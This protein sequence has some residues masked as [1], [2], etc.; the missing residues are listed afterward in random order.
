MIREISV[1]LVEYLGGEAACANW[2]VKWECISAW[3]QA[4][5][6]FQREQEEEEEAR[7][8][9]HRHYRSIYGS[10]S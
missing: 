7:T 3:E 1:S 5:A 10:L 4:A 2:L 8:F 6:K 9:A